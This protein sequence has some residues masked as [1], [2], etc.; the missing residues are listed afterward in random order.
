MLIE[1][2]G[3]EKCGSS[4]GLAVYQ[5]DDESYNGYCWV[6]D[7]YE[8][9][10]YDTDRTSSKFEFRTKRKITKTPEQIAQEI[11]EIKGYPTVDVDARKLRKE[12]LEYFDVKVGLSEQ[13]G[14]TPAFMYFPYTNAE[15]GFTGYKVKLLDPKKQWVIALPGAFKD[16]HFF[17]WPQALQTG[18]KKLMITE[19]EPDALALYQ[20]L[21][22]KQRGTKWEAYDPAVVSIPSGAGSAKKFISKHL[23]DIK[24]HFKEVVLVF[25]QDDAGKEAAREVLDVVPD[26]KITILPGKDANDCVLQGRSKALAEAVLFKAAIPK[27]T[28][29]IMADTLFETA[30]KPAE[31]GLSWPWEQL[32]QLTRGMRFGETYYFGAG[33]KMG[34]SELVNALGKHIMVDHNMPILMAKPEEAN[35]KTVKMVASKVASKIFHD[36]KVEMDKAAYW[37]ATKQFEDKLMLL[38]LYQ[39]VGWKNLK[40]DISAAAAA[41]ARAV[42]IDPITNLTNGIASG[43][44]NTV[45]Q[46]I[47]QTLSEMAKDL[48]IMVFIF[49]HLLKPESGTPHEA[50]GRIYSSQFAGSRAMMRSCNYM[51]GLEGN[52]DESLPLEQRN[53]RHLR[54]LEDREF[55]EVGSVPLYWNHKTGQ[56]TEITT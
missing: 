13:D 23:P 12:T 10:P 24:H 51:M 39:S 31:W 46:D 25:D 26:A 36:P 17:G 19:G 9:N 44:A 34:K 50:G 38:D 27:N 18:A 11:S 54:L 6:C 21:K 28:R 48:N 14:A 41:G 45:L 15:H 42:F 8:P 37:E 32:T 16:V 33:V 43:E 3:H 4:D 1:H 56:F 35:A 7:T 22:D 53:I 29:I 2:I 20:A 55:G 5:A 30:A 49:C 40:L 52:K 47:A